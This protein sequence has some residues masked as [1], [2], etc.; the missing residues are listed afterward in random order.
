M[1]GWD[2]TV[3]DRESEFCQFTE[4]HRV[5]FFIVFQNDSDFFFSGLFM[6]VH[7]SAKLMVGAMVGVFARLKLSA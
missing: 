4:F 6:K 2:A 3:A 5:S 7:P 1:F